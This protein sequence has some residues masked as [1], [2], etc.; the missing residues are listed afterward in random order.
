MNLRRTYQSS[1][2]DKRRF[3]QVAHI[4]DNF[5]Q[6][7]SSFVAKTSGP[8][9]WETLNNIYLLDEDFLWDKGIESEH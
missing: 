9:R 8:C 4:T 2:H 3:H 5:I 6:V 7:R 1:W